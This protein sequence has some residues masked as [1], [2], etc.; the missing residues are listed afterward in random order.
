[1]HGK[2]IDINNLEAFIELDDGRLISV[3][4][5]QISNPSIGSDIYLTNPAPIS[6]NNH[7]FYQYVINPLITNYFQ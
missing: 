4:V 5:C 2:I 3:P 7:S 6:P 1:M